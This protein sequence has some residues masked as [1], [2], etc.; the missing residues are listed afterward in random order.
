MN[1][2][3][4]KYFFYNVEENLK[5]K[6]KKKKAKCILRISNFSGAYIQLVTEPFGISN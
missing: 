2:R 5:K 1:F 4:K 3:A 6:K